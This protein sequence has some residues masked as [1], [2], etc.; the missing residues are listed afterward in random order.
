MATLSTDL[1]NETANVIGSL[2]KL[3][4]LEGSTVLATVD[5][6]FGAPS[7]G[8]I[9]NDPAAVN[10]VASGTADGARLYDSTDANREI[11][12]L[13]VTTTGGG[14]DIELDNTSIASGQSIDM[15]AISYTVPATL[16]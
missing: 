14:G 8:Q 3:E 4:I 11:T 10:A 5:V 6:S 7:S 1:R 15:S 12:G 16:S 13:T 9:T 2:D